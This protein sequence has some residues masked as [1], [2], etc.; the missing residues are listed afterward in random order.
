MSESTNDK[1]FT[2]IEPTCPEEG[3][4]GRLGLGQPDYLR[5]NHEVVVAE[6]WCRGDD[7]GFEATAWF[8]LVDLFTED[9]DHCE[10]LVRQGVVEPLETDY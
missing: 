4:D 5:E 6:A 1:T 2:R 8:P 7:C 10:S 3:C 9:G